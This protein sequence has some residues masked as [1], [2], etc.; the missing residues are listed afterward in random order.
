MLAGALDAVEQFYAGKPDEAIR[1]TVIAT[2][3]VLWLDRNMHVIA[4]VLAASIVEQVRARRRTPVENLLAPLLDAGRYVESA[5]AARNGTPNP[6]DADQ[7]RFADAQARLDEG[8][9][10]TGEAGRAQEAED[11]R[12]TDWYDQAVN[13][14][15]HD[16]FERQ[17]R[18]GRVPQPLPRTRRR[19]P[20]RMGRQRRG[21]ARR[22]PHRLLGR[23]G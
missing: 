10:P 16:E 19:Y 3:L 22:G 23:A 11:K 8:D 7:E 1:Q 15:A 18:R 2:S 17:A 21:N 14:A 20:D 4:N 12:F 6:T 9:Y 13:G 5:R